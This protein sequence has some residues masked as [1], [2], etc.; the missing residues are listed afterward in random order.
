MSGAYENVILVTLNDHVVRMSR[1]EQPYV[2]HIHPNSDETFL[3]IEGIL[4]LELDEQRIELRP[5]ELFTVAR[6]VRHRTA[7]AGRYSINLTFEHVAMETAVAEPPTRTA[8]SP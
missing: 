3:G 5:G 2:W 6:G 7:P 4:I 1:M 8:S